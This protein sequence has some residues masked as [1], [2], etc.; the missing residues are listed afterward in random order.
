MEARILNAK[1]TAVLNAS[2]L[3]FNEKLSPVQIFFE[4]L[5]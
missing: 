2:F 1:N 5:N 3:I 4:T